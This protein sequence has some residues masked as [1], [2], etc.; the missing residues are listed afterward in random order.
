MLSRVNVTLGVLLALTACS[1]PTASE[2]LTAANRCRDQ[3]TEAG[4]D[5]CY[6]AQLGR[7]PEEQAAAQRAAASARAAAAERA[8]RA[9]ITGNPFDALPES[10]FDVL[11]R[12]T[13]RP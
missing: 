12:A 10:A 11:R 9:A 3:Q 4:F 7:I 6:E 1:G 8:E 5:A 13:P 2:R